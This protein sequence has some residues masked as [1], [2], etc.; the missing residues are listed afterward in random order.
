MAVDVSNP[1][2]RQEFSRFDSTGVVKGGD[3]HDLVAFLELVRKTQEAFVSRKIELLLG[4]IEISKGILA[5]LA[6]AKGTSG[7]TCE[8]ASFAKG[9][10]AAIAA[11]A[12]RVMNC[13]LRIMAFPRANP[14]G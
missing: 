13:R 1:R 6:G 7:V 4:P 8:P 12:N 11:S 3:T 2:V 5:W 14:L 10:E 9:I